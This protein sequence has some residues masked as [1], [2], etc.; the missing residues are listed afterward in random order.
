MS[1]E[2][3]FNIRLPKGKTERDVKAFFEGRRH[4]HVRKKSKKRK[5][6]LRRARLFFEGVGNY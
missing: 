3:T 5:K 6:S 2:I 4:S 1:Y